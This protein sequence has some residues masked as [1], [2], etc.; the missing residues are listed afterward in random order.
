VDE[1]VQKVATE[2]PERVKELLLSEEGSCFANV[3]F[4]KDEHGEWALCLGA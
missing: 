1:A 4:Q 3:P 2:G